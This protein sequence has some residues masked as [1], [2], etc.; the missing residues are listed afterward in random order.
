MGTKMAVAFANIPCP[1]IERE[2][3]RQSC[4]KL[5][6]WERC[7]DDVFSLVEYCLEKIEKF[8]EKE[9][10]HSS[11]LSNGTQ[12]CTKL[13]MQ[14]S[15]MEWRRIERPLTIRCAEALVPKSLA[16]LVEPLVREENK[17]VVKL[18]L[19]SFVLFCLSNKESVLDVQTHY[20]PME[21]FHICVT[22]R[23]Y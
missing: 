10:T 7:I 6:V 17:H 13:K 18:T 1:K 4:Q 9:N 2:I 19:K 16:S 8:L 11:Q 20:K 22:T 12:R 3:L 5:L 21:N 14:I 15:Q 23:L